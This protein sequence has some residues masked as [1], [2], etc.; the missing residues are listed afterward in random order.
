MLAGK[1]VLGLKRWHHVA[2]VRDGKAVTVYLDGKPEITGEADRV[3]GDLPLFLGGRCDNFAN[4]AGKLDEVAVYDRVLTEKEVAE[5]A[6]LR[7]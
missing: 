4:L 3:E 2:L 7:K 5:R 1:T 6:S